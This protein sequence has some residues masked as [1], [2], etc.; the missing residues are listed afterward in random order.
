MQNL[1]SMQTGCCM[2]ALVLQRGSGTA[3]S[4]TTVSA[5]MGFL[6]AV[7]ALCL[8][9]LYLTMLQVRRRLWLLGCQGQ[10]PWRGTVT[11]TTLNRV[12]VVVF[13]GI[14]RPPGDE[15]RGCQAQLRFAQQGSCR[16]HSG[17]VHL[18]FM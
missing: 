1:W 15:G 12:F 4:L 6:A 17:C 2:L 5:W 3:G 7:G 14:L 8:T 16:A 11:V 13:R 9:V 18:S 10:A